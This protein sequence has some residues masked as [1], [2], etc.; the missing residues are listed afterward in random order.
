[1]RNMSSYS[2]KLK[3]SFKANNSPGSISELEFILKKIKP[4]YYPL[5]KRQTSQ[6]RFATPVFN[7]SSSISKSGV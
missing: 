6:L 3:N 2:F 5:R 4:G 1:M 7:P